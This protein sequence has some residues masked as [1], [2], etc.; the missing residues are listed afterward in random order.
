M[1]AATRSLIRQ[2]RALPASLPVVAGLAAGAAL[3]ATGMVGAGVQGWLVELG[4]LLV[5][6]AVACASLWRSWRSERPR[7]LAAEIEGALLAVLLVFVLV[8]SAEGALGTASVYPLIYLVLAL[9]V[10][11][12][13]RAVGLAAVLGA[14]ALEL[15]SALLGTAAGASAAAPSLLLAGVDATTLSARLGFFAAFGLFASAVHGAEVAERRQR[16]RQEVEQ[17]RED[18]LRAAREYRLFHSERLETGVLERDEAEELIACDAAEAVGHTVYVSLRLLK[19]ALRCHTCVLLW[20]DLGQDRLR[21]RELVSDSD[22]VVE[23]SIE[24]ARGVIGGITRRREAVSL[25]DLRPGFRGLSYYARQE[26]GPVRHFLGVPLLEHGHLRGVLCVD[27]SQ[28]EAPFAVED[29]QVVEEATSY[30]LRAVQNERLF[31][32]IDRTKYELSR[33]FEASRR[34]NDVLTP[35][36]VYRVA[37]EC[38]ADI[39]PY[40]IAAVTWYDDEAD[41]HSIERI[42]CRPKGP[43]L[44]A[45]RIEGWQGRRFG[46]DRGLVAMVIKNR[47]Y[48]PFGGQLKAQEQMIFGQEERMGGM[49]ELR[50]ALILPLVVQDRA[51]GTLVLTHRQERCY[52]SD[53]REMLEVVA[54]QIAISLQNARLYAQMED[55]ATRDG[56]TGLA[57]RRSFNQRLEEVIARH[58]RSGKTFGLLLTDIDHFK[59]VNDTYG[60]PVGDEVLRRVAAVFREGLREIDYPARYGGEEFVVILEET[61]LQGCMAIAQRLRQAV[62]A[63]VYQTEQGPF[64]CTISMGLGLWPED[65]EAPEE[66]ID[67]ADQALYHSKESGRDRATAYGTRGRKKGGAKG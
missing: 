64:S 53:R 52:G 59:S 4:G 27:R 18:M 29:V 35:Q 22:E 21:I 28:G 34:L 12:H 16:H 32:G 67:L 5:V 38:V 55:L 39:A 13:Q 61:D 19:R 66:L 6:G 10:S 14:C 24:P 8:R 23:G 26:A 9:I 57:N 49:G 33:F 50:S 40:E 51:V 56:L 63:Q 58:R 62:K 11:L 48:L 15:S 60:H 47:H 30:I 65:A 2:P 37:L 54:N 1:S 3:Y 17:E 42:V 43:G 41:R 7:A 31:V 20:Y 36:D 44:D 46:G 45:E 25:R